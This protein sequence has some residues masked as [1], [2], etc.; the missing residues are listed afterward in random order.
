VSVI[1]PYLKPEESNPH[2]LNLFVQNLLLYNPP[3]CGPDV[4]SP[5]FPSDLQPNFCM[6]SLFLPWEI[7]RQYHLV[8]LYNLFCQINS[9]QKHRTAP[10]LPVYLLTHRLFN[11]AFNSS[12]FVT[13]SSRIMYVLL[14]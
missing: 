1:D 7:R 11:G 4:T 13:P 10:N 12:Y 6:H 5:L 9:I 2:Q 3:T 8:L 14:N